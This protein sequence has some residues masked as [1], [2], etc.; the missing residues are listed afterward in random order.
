[1]ALYCNQNINETRTLVSGPVY[2]LRVIINDTGAAGSFINI[3]DSVSG[4]GTLVA[5][6]DSTTDSVRVYEVDLVNGLTY[7]TTGNP[8][9]FTIVYGT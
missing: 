2:F 5:K 4:S 3:Y 6:I 1:M 8:G 9:N 7:V